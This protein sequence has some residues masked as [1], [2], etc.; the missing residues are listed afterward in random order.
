MTNLNN[1][2]LPD[3]RIMHI[4]DGRTVDPKDYNWLQRVVRFLLRP[5]TESWHHRD[6]IAAILRRELR[7]RF[8]GSM[9]GWVWA[10][11]APVISL[12]TYTIVFDGAVKLPNNAESKS[13]I[14]YALFVFGGLVAFNFFT[15]MAYRAPSL[16]HEYAHY[17]KQTMFPAEML[18]IISTLRATTYATIGLVLMLLCQLIFAGSLHWTVLLLPLWFIPFL[19]FLIGITWLLSA[20]GAFTRDTAYLMMT[21]APV[22]MF[23]TP[24]FYSHETLSP[25]ARFWMYALNVLTGFIEIIRDLVVFGKIPNGLV[26]AWTLFISMFFFWFGYWFF[27]RQQDAIADVI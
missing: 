13:S 15:E 20:M 17:I 5:F 10:V 1:R 16:L 23:A 22:L 25:D 3:A 12:V 11:V 19:A 2:Q 26:I 7:E 9:A 8:S 14:D 18:P 4:V 24:V 6:L 21:I 27:R